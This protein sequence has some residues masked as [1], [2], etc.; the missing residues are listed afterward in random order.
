MAVVSNRFADQLNDQI[1]NEFAAHLQY[2]AV[3]TYYDAATM[4]KMAAHFYAQ[5]M[6]EHV[7][8]RM[9]IQF[10]LDTGAS[11]RLPAVAEPVNE[12]ADIAAPVALALDQERR[13]T[14]Q[15]YGLTRTAREDFDFAAEQFMQWFIKEQVEEVASMSDLLTVVRRSPDDI[16][17]IEE[18]V[19]AV[20]KG[21]VDPTAPSAAG[22]TADA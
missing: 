22:S 18:F 16:R 2:L 12:F 14:D 19:A 1:A 6:E 9:M 20:P 10:L 7:H 11:V 21:D 4:P 15:I 5:A 13:V 17:A 3:A 8:A